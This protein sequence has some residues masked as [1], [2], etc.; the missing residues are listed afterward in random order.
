M[1]IP[2]FLRLIWVGNLITK[3]K[4]PAPP[5]RVYDLGLGSEASGCYRF[6]ASGFRLQGCRAVLGLVEGNPKP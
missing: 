6:L 5:G 2:S 3:P 4:P 1:V